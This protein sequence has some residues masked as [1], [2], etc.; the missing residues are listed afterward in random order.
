[1]NFN[2][3]KRLRFIEFI[4]VFYGSISRAELMAYYGIGGAQ[5]TRD[6]SDYK[7]IAPNNLILNQS[8]KRWLKTDNFKAVY[9]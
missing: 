9:K 8:S 7:K 5:A 4:L 6:F 2:L 3:E 1:M